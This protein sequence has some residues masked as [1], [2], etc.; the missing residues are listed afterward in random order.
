MQKLFKAQKQEARIIL[1]VLFSSADM[2]E[3]LNSLPLAEFYKYRKGTTAY[4]CINHLVP[5]Y[6]CNAFHPQSHVHTRCTRSSQ[7]KILQNF[8]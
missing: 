4:K 3:G 7:N 1:E 5:E 2:F 8:F 6:L